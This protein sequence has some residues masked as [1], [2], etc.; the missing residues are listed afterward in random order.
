MPEHSTIR[1]TERW[2]ATVGRWVPTAAQAVPVAAQGA[3]LPHIETRT[4]PS[5]GRRAMAS[6]ARMYAAARQTRNT[7]GFGSG[8]AST[9]ADAELATSLPM[10]RSRARQMVRDSSYAKRAKAIV[11]DNVIG[12]GVG[13]QAQVETNRTGLNDVVNSDIERAFAEWCVADSC[14]T[15]GKLHFHDLERAAFG[16]IFEAG[17]V[18]IRMHFERFGRSEVPIAL[19]LIEAERLAQD[20]VP[21][22]AG[23][24]AD[25]R[26]GVEVDRFCRPVA[27][28]I[29]QL[30]AGDIRGLHGSPDRY[31]RVPA[32]EIFHL[33]VVDR[34]P[35]T[36][37]EPW[38][39]T[40][41]RK[42]D[43]MNEY[44]QAELIAAR[45]SAHYFATITTPEPENGV[46]DDE[47]EDG[48]QVMD[49]QPLTIQELNP[50]EQLQFHAPN[51]PNTAMDPFM[52][53]MLREVAAGARSSY[54][55]LS[56]DYSQSNYSSSR[57]GLLED[58]DTWRI[59]QQFWIRA[60]RQPFHR[61]W[62]QQAVLAGAVPFV[63][64]VQ[65]G[66][67]PKKFEA[68]LF[69]PRGWSWIDPTSEVK[70]YAQAVSGGFTT[71]TDVIAATGNGQ[72]IED[73]IKTRQRELR[74][75]KEAEILVDT[76]VSAPTPAPAAAPSTPTQPQAEEG[77]AARARVVPMARTA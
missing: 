77:A 30:H 3:Q 70:A 7:V 22:I 10:M 31:E 36:R 23:A 66:A 40:A 58:R 46:F 44:T 19:E 21:A 53:A 45:G 62:L 28:W 57:M 65:Y 54:E 59:F 33:Y 34:W 48:Q 16:Q 27:Y 26:M 74:L 2:D 51:R 55:S 20:L 11:V 18:L 49:L 15:G 56:R 32:S 68:V 43:D 76:T 69:K 60:F 17:E 75:L 67:R 50:G 24:D 14:H 64:L 29:R 37:G 41:L 39:H 72:D 8:G 42:L 61:R 35:Q 52:R 5:A 71:L 25:V 13:M 12:A 9:S 63:P 38:L 4:A 47:E 1:A 6:A 73:Y